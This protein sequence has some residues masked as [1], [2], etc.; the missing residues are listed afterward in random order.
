MCVAILL[1]TGIGSNQVISVFL[2]KMKN[3]ETYYN[4][5]NSHDFRTSADATLA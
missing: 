5:A 2:L 3:A 4:V 1:P